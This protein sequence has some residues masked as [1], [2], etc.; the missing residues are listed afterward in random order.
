[1]LYFLSLSAKFEPCGTC[2]GVWCFASTSS[3]PDHYQTLGIGRSATA[4][5]IKS[6]F[7]EL[8][9]KYHPDCHS[10]EKEKTAAAEKFQEVVRAYEVL[11]SKDKKREYDATLI[12]RPVGAKGLNKTRTK[13]RGFAGKSYLDLDVDYKTFEHF[14]RSMRRNYC[15]MPDEFYAEFGGRQFTSDYKG[16]WSKHTVKSNF[17]VQRESEERRI[18]KETEELKKKTS[19]L[20]RFEDYKTSIKAFFAMLVVSVI[21]LALQRP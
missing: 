18:W 7:Y 9:K 15:E 2:G 3:A 4:A 8:S 21:A 10:G 14:Q 11:R 13:Y 1:M 16:R 19:H 6:A 17:S 5:Q 12:Q 20:P